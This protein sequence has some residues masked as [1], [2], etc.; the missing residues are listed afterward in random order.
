MVDPTHGLE[1]QISQWRAYLRRRQAIHAVDVEELEDHL[2]VQVA[3][4]VGAGLS[5][6]EAF[7]VAVKR[8]GDLDAL[9]REFARE[10]SERLWKHLVMGPKRRAGA[11]TE[12]VV[13]VSLAIIAALAVKV[14]ELF[15]RQL[16]G[17]DAGFYARNVSLFVLPIL[18]GYFAWKRELDSVGRLWLLLPFVVAGAFAN[19]FPFAPGGA[20]EVLTTLH[21]P[22]ALWLVVGIAYAG[23]WWHSGGGRMD[24]VKFSGELFIT[25]SLLPSAAAFSQASRWGCSNRSA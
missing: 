25:T 19:V 8:M 23:G 24:F 16:N 9:S 11:R 15:D 18:T 14:P 12:S 3:T 10:Y 13:V 5:V 22:I 20:T 1:G 2:R 21:L 7:L 6:D 4:L 17:E